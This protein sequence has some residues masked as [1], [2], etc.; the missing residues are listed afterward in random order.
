M[1]RD[2][3]GHD[4]PLGIGQRSPRSSHLECQGKLHISGNLAGD[5]FGPSGH[6]GIVERK[7]N[8]SS[9]AA[10]NNTA[11]GGGEGGRGERYKTA[12]HISQSGIARTNSRGTSELRA[13]RD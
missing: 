8:G 6:D 5:L 13:K 3:G 2:G 10:G 12:G 1:L 7:E 11:Q 4:I 9:H